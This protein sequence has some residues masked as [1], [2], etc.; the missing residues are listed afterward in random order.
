MVIK[1]VVFDI[2]GVIQASVE[3]DVLYPL[4]MEKYGFTYEQIKTARDRSW[5]KFGR[6]E[7]TEEKHWRN[8]LQD[9]GV[10]EDIQTF[11]TGAHRATLQ[12]IPGTREVIRK[13]KEKGIAL[14]IL[15]NHAVE[16]IIPT[17]FASKLYKHFPIM[18]ISCFTG[19]MKPER[20]IYELVLKEMETQPEE[21]VYIDDQEK[22]LLPARELG[23]LTIKFESAPQLEQELKALGA[24]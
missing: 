4:L 13:L 17:I 1:A 16:W 9:L 12:K 22:N 18:V 8:I 2:G 19:L 20:A 15:S 21:T 5:Q 11:I 23:M 14:A 10:Q 3:G 7:I 24:L 6:G